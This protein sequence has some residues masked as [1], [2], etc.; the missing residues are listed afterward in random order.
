MGHIEHGFAA[1][2]V[3]HDQELAGRASARIELLDG[4]I[5]AEHGANALVTTV[6]EVC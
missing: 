1:L 5:V 6:S 2:Y 4:R 3:T